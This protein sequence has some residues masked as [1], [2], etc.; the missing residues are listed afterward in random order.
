L[1]ICNTSYDTKKANSQ[2][3]SLTPNH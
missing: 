3:S 2:T 1:D